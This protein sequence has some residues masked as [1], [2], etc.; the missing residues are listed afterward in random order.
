MPHVVIQYT[1]N[2]EP[3]VDMQA[4]CSEVCA[5]LIAQKDETGGPLFPVGGTRVFAYPA[6]AYAVADGKGD[7][8]FCYVFIRV[9]G[10]RSE[11]AKKRAGDAVLGKLQTRFASAFAKKHIG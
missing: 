5:A 8:G 6:H 9:A 1:A 3:E 10:G 4:L 11:A 2:L 7:Y